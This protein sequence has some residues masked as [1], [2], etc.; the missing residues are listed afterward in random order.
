MLVSLA[1]K[2]ARLPGFG[3]FMGY[4]GLA[5]PTTLEAI[6]LRFVRDLP[7]PGEASSETIDYL[8][9]FQKAGEHIVDQWT[10]LDS[11]LAESSPVRFGL[12]NGNLDTGLADADQRLI[13]WE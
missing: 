6:D 7:R 2:T 5:Y 13:F 12:P 1:E 10:Q 4:R 9:V 8:D 11:A 3:D